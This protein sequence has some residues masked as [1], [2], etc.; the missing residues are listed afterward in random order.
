MEKSSSPVCV[1]AE[2]VV[3]AYEMCFNANLAREAWREYLQAWNP[4]LD[5]FGW[6]RATGAVLT[7]EMVEWLQFV[8]KELK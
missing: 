7:D 2:F 4:A 8:Q 1:H 5:D 3:V 6:R